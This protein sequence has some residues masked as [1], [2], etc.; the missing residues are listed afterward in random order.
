MQQKNQT[1]TIDQSSLLRAPCAAKLQHQ[2]TLLRRVSNKQKQTKVNRRTCQTKPNKS[3]AERALPEMTR[4]VSYGWE[5][6]KVKCQVLLRQRALWISK[7]TI[8]VDGS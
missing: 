3:Q 1:L 5:E 8:Y 2:V 7:W 4:S 6:K